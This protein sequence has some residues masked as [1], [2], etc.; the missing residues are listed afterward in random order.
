MGLQGMETI[1][2]VSDQKGHEAAIAATAMQ[3]DLEVV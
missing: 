3:H 2:T 1:D